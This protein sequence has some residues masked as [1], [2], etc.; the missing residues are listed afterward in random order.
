M[1][2]LDVNIDSANNVIDMA[3]GDD[4]F[5]KLRKRYRKCSVRFDELA[6]TDSLPKLKVPMKKAEGHILNEGKKINW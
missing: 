3:I 5:S 6:E 4:A 1:N 2:E